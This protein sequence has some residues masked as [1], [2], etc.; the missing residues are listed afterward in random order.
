ME[1][2]KQLGQNLRRL[3][4]ERGL[5]QEQLALEAGLDMSYISE[6]ESGQWNITINTALKLTE[7]LAVKL[8]DLLEGLD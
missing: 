8:V 7:A 3:R 2:A 4:K 5:T 6:V 1:P